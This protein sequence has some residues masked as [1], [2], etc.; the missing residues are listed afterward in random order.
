MKDLQWFPPILEPRAASVRPILWSV[1]AGA[2]FG[3]LLFARGHRILALGVWVVT[4]LLALGLSSQSL[5]RHLLRAFDWL[6]AGAGRVTTLAVLWPFYVL[7]FGAIRLALSAARIDLLGLRLRRE[8]PSYWRP[9]APETKRAKYYERLFTV[10]PAGEQS[11]VFAWAIGILAFVL[12]LA[13][14]SELI[15]RSMGFGNPI[16][17]RVD[18]RIGYYPA[19]HQD[20]HRYGGEIHIN[21]FGMRCRDVAAEKPAGTFRILMLG[22]STLYGGSYIDQKQTYAARLEY[23]LNQ[24][25][26]E[27]PNSP[28]RVEV[29]SMGVNGWGPQ[30]ELAYVNAFGLF[31]ADLVMVMGP[32]ADAYRPRYGIEHFPFFAE[33]HRP[34]FAWQ[35]F[36]EHLRW[37]HN[38][39]STGGSAGFDSGSREGQ[40][41]A[42]GVDAW[43]GIA[44]LAQAQG[45][46]TDFELLPNEDEARKGRAGELTQLVLDR[47][48]PELAGRRVSEAYP[49][50]LIRSNLGVPKLY[51]D[52]AHLD[53]SGHRIYAQYLRDR[54]LQVASAE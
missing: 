11:H 7:V 18:P 29:L 36:W 50:P 27:L 20:V 31:H 26:G 8:Q 12:L 19:P 54:V 15:L 25:P 39:R 53:V 35:E 21:A 52:G 5:R 41:L 38:Q 46:K 13:G 3:C 49:L 37:Q 44:T 28:R 30:H 23:L 40:V 24:N 16:V 10:E 17:Y 34:D 42:E 14:S 2:A 33:G 4:S 6:G 48:L 43:I 9:A 32:P 22:D 47:L 45:S 51:H 1:V